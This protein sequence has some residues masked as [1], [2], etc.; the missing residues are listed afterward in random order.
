MLSELNSKVPVDDYDDYYV[1]T[2]V[3]ELQP[4]NDQQSE[5]SFYVPLPK[6]RKIAKKPKLK[7]SN[8]KVNLI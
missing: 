2:G 4:E 6:K 5:H 3:V 7:S 8:L 1:E